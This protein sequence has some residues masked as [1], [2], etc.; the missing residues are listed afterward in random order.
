MFEFLDPLREVTT[1][2]VFIKMFLAV[3]CGGAIGIKS[4]FNRHTN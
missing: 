3:I 2:S 1:I 4:G